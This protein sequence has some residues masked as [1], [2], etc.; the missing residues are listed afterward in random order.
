[1][2]A[3]T[4]SLYEIEQLVQG[5]PGRRSDQPAALNATIEAAR[6]GET[7]RGFALVASEVKALATQTAKATEEIETQIPEMQR[8]TESSVAAIKEIGDTIAKISEISSAIAVAVEQRGS[9]TRRSH[10]TSTMPRVARRRCP[11]ASKRLTARRVRYRYGR[12][13]GA[14][15]CGVAKESKRLTTKVERSLATVRAA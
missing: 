4:A 1:M 11:T 12:L 3:A 5:L 10:A 7:G 8:A 2:K 9:A 14:R 6:A 13:S 15:L